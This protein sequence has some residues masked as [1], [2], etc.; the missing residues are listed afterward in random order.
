MIDLDKEVGKVLKSKPYSIRLTPEQHNF[1]TR[2][3]PNF[4]DII[5]RDIDEVRLKKVRR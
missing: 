4:A 2:D 5:R 3:Y 1:I